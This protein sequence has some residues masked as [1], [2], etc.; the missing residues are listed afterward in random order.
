MTDA[1]VRLGVI[2]QGVMGR[3]HA[4]V[5]TDLEHVELVGV[6]DAQPQ[7]AAWASHKFNTRAFTDYAALL[8]QAAPDAVV[9]AV[10]TRHHLEVALAA[11]ERGC[12][13]LV[14]KPITS[15]AAEARTLVAAAAATERILTVGHIERF[16]PAVRALKQH[17]NR[18]EL[19][20]VFK[21]HA[22]RLGPFP[23]RVRDVGVVVDL[24]TH[25]LDVMAFLLGSAIK[26]VYAETERRVATEHEDMLNALLKFEN[27]TV[28]V[29][30]VNWLTPTKVRDIEVLGERGMF[31]VDYLTQELR[32]YENAVADGDWDALSVLTGV[33]EGNMT[34]YHI[35]RAEPL[36]LELASFAAAIRA[37]TPPEVTA[38]QGLNAL[39]AALALVASGRSG[40]PVAVGAPAALA[41]TGA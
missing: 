39:E 27:G 22:R 7:V 3:N 33:S 34:R 28:G 14:E 25:D 11:L 9:V 4:R 20:R 32:F 40:E 31:R 12:H 35:E 30:D 37:G 21:A 13:V 19:G 6:A 24:A 38:E 29:L 17:L 1:V 10:P 15:T 16:N 26:R 8:D 2:G 41:G 36:R 23:A 5:L 18:G